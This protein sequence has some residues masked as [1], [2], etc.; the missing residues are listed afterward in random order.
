MARRILFLIASVVFAL[1]SPARA[2]E[3]LY[4]QNF[5]AAPLDK[6]PEDFMVLSGAFV[7][8]SEG[9]N[10]FLELPG[11]PLDTFGLLFGPAQQSDVS[12]TGRFHGRKQ[13]RK[14][15]TFGISLNGVAGYRLQV[16]PAKKALELLKSDEAK[17]QVEYAWEADQWTAL[18][19]QVRHV[20]AKWEIEGKAW[21]AARPE[22]A[23]WMIK[24]EESQEPPSGRAGIWGMPFS[25]HPIRFDDL[26][27]VRAGT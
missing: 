5:E 11:S 3:P 10:K 27:V 9:D 4:S 6:A 16:N 21:P 25:G 13:G 14:F 26:R 23:N 20:G 15:P 7:V 19:I 24:F 8:K 18:R 17:A 2:A 12:A 22:P 1:P